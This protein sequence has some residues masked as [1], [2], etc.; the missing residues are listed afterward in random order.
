MTPT[1]VSS[2][3]L[4]H[5]AVVARSLDEGLAHVENA[6]G[7]AM[8]A[9]GEH[10]EMGTHNHLLRLGEGLFLEV[11]A[12][13]PAAP[14]PA[15]ARWFDLDR[16]G[17]AVPHLATWIVRTDDLDAALAGA[18]PAAGPAIQ[19]SRDALTWRIAVPEDGSLPYAGAYPTIIEWQPGPHPT[20]R[21]PDLGYGLL[22]LKVEHPDVEDI[23][24]YLVDTFE[25][26][27]VAVEVGPR[28]RLTAGIATPHGVR[29]LT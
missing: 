25:D 26:P 6:L 20:S 24:A 3:T 8:P 15:R 2:L 22:D 19:V 21:M 27:R 1:A 14:A 4:D 17:H 11:I 7:V 29:T 16:L 28:V 10:R 23:G 12:I 5:L 9:G 13:N 18:P